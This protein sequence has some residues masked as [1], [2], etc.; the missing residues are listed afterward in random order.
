M[1]I[2]IG[3]CGLLELGA[4]VYA[5]CAINSPEWLLRHSAWAEARARAL[6]TFREVQARHQASAAK[7]LKIS[8]PPAKAE[9]P[10]RRMAWLMNKS[11]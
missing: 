4:L 1:D 3:L 10:N 8:N 6:T 11:K 7:R 2:I 9:E 5:L